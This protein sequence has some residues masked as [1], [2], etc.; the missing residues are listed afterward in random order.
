MSSPFYLARTLSFGDKTCPEADL[1]NASRYVVVLAEPG[2]GK[3]SLLQSLASQLKTK[4]VTANMFSALGES[5]IPG[6]EAKPVA[7]VIDALDE[8]AKIDKLGLDKVFALARKTDPSHVILSSRSSEWDEASTHTFQQFFD[9][10]PL[11]VR[12]CEFDIAEQSAIFEHHAPNEDFKLFQEEVARFD[13]DVLLSN[14]QFLKLFADAYLESDRRFIDKRSIFVKALERLA[15]EANRTV[16]NS[17]QLL[18]TPQKIDLASKCFAE[19]LLSGAEGVSSNEAAES[20]MY[21]WLL[22]LTGK[23]EDSGILATRLFKP[24]EHPSQH[25]PVHKIIAEYCAA[26][27]LSKR[28]KDKQGLSLRQCLSII[29]PKSTVRDELRGLLGWLAALG[30]ETIQEAAIK[31]DPYAILAN[32]DPSQLAPSSKRLLLHQLKMIEADDPNFRRGDFWRRFS[33][34]GFFTQDVVAELKTLLTSTSEGN[35]RDLMLELLAESPVIGELASELQELVLS[36]QESDHTRSLANSRLVEIK[37]HD[38]RADLKVLIS[39]ASQ[40]SLELAAKTIQLLGIELCE[41]AYVIDFF[42]AC[43]KLYPGHDAMHGRAIGERYFIKLFIADLELA[44]IEWLLDDLTKVLACQCGKKSYECDCR[45]GISKIVGSMLDRYFCLATPPFDP[46]RV[47]QWVG[48]LNFH[49]DYNAGESKAVEMLRKNDDL[50]QGIFAHVLTGMTNRE[51]IFEVKH[52]K[53]DQPAHAGLYLSADDYLFIVD[54]AF[55]TNNPT[56]W[57]CFMA[58][59]QNYRNKEERGPNSLRKLMR[60]QAL[61]KPDFMRPWAKANRWHTQFERENRLRRSKSKRRARRRSKHQNDIRNRNFKF[62]YENRE[63]IES[64]RH[65]NSLRHFAELVL[66]SPEQIERD[67]GNASIVRSALRN[68]LDFIAPD[69]PDL[70]K[71]GA[72][73]GTSQYLNVEMVLYAACLEIFRRNGNLEGTDPKLLKALL[74]K[75]NVGYPAVTNDERAALKQ[76]VD[77]LIFSDSKNAEDF[78]RQYVE[79]QLAQPA[80]RSPKIEMLRHDEVFSHLRNSLSIEWLRRFPNLALEPLNTLF[81]IAAQYGERG[82]LTQLIGE[83]CAQFMANHPAPTGNDEVEQKRIFWLVRAWYFLPDAPETYWNWLKADK[84]SIFVLYGFSGRSSRH[85][86]PYWPKLTPIK[87]EA[88]LTAFI[89]QWPK[90]DLPDCYGTDSPS[91][92]EAYRFLSEIMWLIDSDKSGDAIPVLDRLLADSRFSDMHRDMKSLRAAQVRKKALQDFTP[93]TPQQIVDLLDRNMVAT[94]EGLRQLVIDELQIYQDDIRGGEFNP[95]KRFYAN[96]QRLDEPACTEIIAE[97]LKQCLQGQNITVTLE[98]H[99]KAAKRSD[100]TVAKIIDGKR[101]MLVTEVKGQWHRELYSAAVEQLYAR[102]AIH[103]DAEQQGI[104][105]VIWFGSKEEIAGLRNHGIASADAL[106]N[107]IE[108]RLPHELKGR[109]DVFV[110]DVSV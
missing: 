109:I 77:R 7:L 8:L 38:H 98:H 57:A 34:A 96:G 60:Q 21:P 61:E 82:E 104:Y 37:S 47:W 30:D 39:E 102:Y 24:G 12:L 25:R 46:I 28:I 27:Y 35:L 44:T 84:N 81:E 11:V 50:R 70:P 4:V 103:P 79:P 89:T 43:A 95:V 62:F 91:E 2:G 42:T 33:V 40:T 17:A 1:F 86:Y 94:V 90:V 76:E 23:T 31:L 26:D 75:F 56:L 85:D 74:T 19:L 18:T 53:F 59:H 106:K 83:R 92:E 88:I 101:R 20:R 58:H 54:L 22:S 72:L 5:A 97:R 108:A 66:M 49:E 80:C 3:T 87:V 14:P 32:G 69:I 29:A 100:F 105:L 36:P 16:T 51:T 52:F 78:L 68:C 63:L 13:L 10:S 64:G 48:N 107:S 45:N 9:K 71:L 93:P 110:L 73:H 41:R 55:I 65:W 67:V 15:K 99:L 6:A